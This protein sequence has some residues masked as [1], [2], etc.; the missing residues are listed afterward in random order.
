VWLE[1][2][3]TLRKFNTSLG[4]KSMTFWQSASTIYGISCTYDIVQSDESE[5]TL[6]RN[7]LAPSSA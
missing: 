7:V 4:L 5:L 3:G 6:L 2:L 1:G